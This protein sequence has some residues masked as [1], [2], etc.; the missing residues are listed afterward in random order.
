MN[1]YHP[2]QK[3]DFSAV[4]AFLSTLPITSL[5]VEG[6]NP[7]WAVG[8]VRPGPGPLCTLI[9]KDHLKYDSNIDDENNVAQRISCE[10]CDAHSS[11]IAFHHNEFV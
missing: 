1:R 11:N 8:V 7:G 4:A 2:R 5:T 9:F 6:S 10:L 3:T